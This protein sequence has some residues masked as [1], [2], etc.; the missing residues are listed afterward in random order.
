MS[1]SAAKGGLFPYTQR[2]YWGGPWYPYWSL[3]L[4]SI[5]GGLVGLDHLYLRSPLTAIAKLVVNILGLGI[6]YLYD[7]IQI[8]GE[9]DS[10]LKN[11]LSIPAFGP[12]GIGS[13]MFK[14]DQPD[15]EPSKSPLRY[16][17]YM[18][19]VFFP[20][21]FDSFLAGD[22]KGALAKFFSAINPFFWIIAILWV[23]ISA[24]SAWF[25]PTSVFEKG[26]MRLFP[27]SVV[28]DANGPSV[29]GP[30][31]AEA[32]KEESK[33]FF[34]TILSTI[35]NF[36]ASIFSILLPGLQPAAAA[37]TGVVEA[38]ATATKQ[39]IEAATAPAVQTVGTAS[40]LVQ[41]APEAA[42]AIPALT[43]G[44]TSNLQKYTTVDG[45]KAAAAVQK[46]GGDV[47]SP[48][49]NGAL[50]LF[51]LMTIGIGTWK[52]SSHLNLTFPFWQRQ[53][54]NGRE[55]Q[56]DTPPKPATV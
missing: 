12:A 9:K 34:G 45:L 10:I 6:W 4:V 47:E 46:G 52:A 54:N 27:F 24:G 21:G 17:A 40:S 8:L 48:L 22:T 28:M 30:G 50:L 13:G 16:L 43:A 15:A 31:E 51:F 53:Q 41:K 36:F 44:V 1:D 3:I 14:D 7:L 25:N 23:L 35:T 33:G 38:G 20:F 26:P 37:M 55:Q 2:S 42:A 49:S 32:P 18:F 11:G 56:N 39:V 19:L 29:L 5:L